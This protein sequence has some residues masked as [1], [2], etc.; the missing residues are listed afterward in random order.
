MLLR[1]YMHTAILSGGLGRGGII[2]AVM[3][4]SGTHFERG[5]MTDDAKLALAEQHVIGSRAERLPTAS[6]PSPD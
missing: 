4:G 5:V 1:G 6:G 3:V 2:D